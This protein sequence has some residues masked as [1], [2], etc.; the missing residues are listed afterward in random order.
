[1]AK[2]PKPKPPAW[3]RAAGAPRV[4]APLDLTDTPANAVL[5][6]AEGDV[7]AARACI[8]L[9]EASQRHDPGS[10]FGPFTPLVMLDR[11]KLRGRLIARL[12]ALA[13]GDPR[14]TLGLLHALRLGAIEPGELARALAGQAPPERREALLA[15]ADAVPVLKPAR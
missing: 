4:G 15:V 3:A 2:S 5:K 11:F 6:L 12:H 13:G 1:M 8:A 10:E 7:A 9:I 14:R